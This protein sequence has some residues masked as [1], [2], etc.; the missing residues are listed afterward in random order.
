MTKDFQKLLNE[1]YCKKEVIVLFTVYGSE[2]GQEIGFN[3]RSEADAFISEFK[4][5]DTRHKVEV[6]NVA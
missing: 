2:E 4:S 6:L 1:K 3:S 5:L